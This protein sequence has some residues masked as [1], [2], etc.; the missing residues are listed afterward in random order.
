MIQRP[1]RESL[2]EPA[3]SLQCK[4]CFEVLS[5]S[6]RIA[7]IGVSFFLQLE[8]CPEKRR[9]EFIVKGRVAVPAGKLRRA[10]FIHVAPTGLEL[11]FSV[12]F[13]QTR[14]QFGWKSS[15]HLLAMGRLPS[16]H[17]AASCP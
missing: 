16:A 12:R 5:S 15:R 10:I 13:L 1:T 4:E 7:G 6:R 3:G 17:S 11:I 2:Y 9:Y 14:L 8:E